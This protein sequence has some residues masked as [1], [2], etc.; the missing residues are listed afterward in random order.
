MSDMEEAERMAENTSNEPEQPAEAPS[1]ESVPA[2][3]PA[4]DDAA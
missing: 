4:E 3:E 1:E 2:E